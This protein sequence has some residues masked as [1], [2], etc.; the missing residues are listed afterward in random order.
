MMGMNQEPLVNDPAQMAAANQ[1][2]VQIIQTVGNDPNVAA[3]DWEAF[4]LL[5]EVDQG[6]PASMEIKGYLYG[7]GDSWGPLPADYPALQPLAG[8]LYGATRGPDGSPWKKCLVQFH[9]PGAATMLFEYNDDNRWVIT[10]EDP[11][12]LPAEIR[13][14]APA[15]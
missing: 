11:N 1:A 9:K 8:G 5:L 12:A 7:Q 4:T 10:Q 3:H 13:P 2:M 14:A 15:S 6:P